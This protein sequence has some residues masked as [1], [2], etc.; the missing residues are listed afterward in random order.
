MTR[1]NVIDVSLLTDQHLMA[2]YRELPMIAGSLRRSLK[3]KNGLPKVPPIYKLGSGH[4]TFFYN[5]GLFLYRR[6]NAIIEE[7]L[8]RGYRLDSGR[9][10][11]FDTFKDNGLYGDWIANEI[12]LLVNANRITQRIME[13]FN[14][15]KYFGKPLVTLDNKVFEDILKPKKL[16]L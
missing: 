13:K 11:D 16:F 8:K 15:Y 3:S 2:E 7:L 1:I 10:V 14:F 4:V 6:Y 5:K 9:E 12:D